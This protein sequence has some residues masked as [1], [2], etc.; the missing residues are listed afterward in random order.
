MLEHRAAASL[1]LIGSLAC[2]SCSID[3]SGEGAQ[4]TEEKRFQVGTEVNLTVRTFDGAIEVRSWDRNEVAVQI[5]RR[6]PTPQE[7]EALEVRT[8]QEGNRIVI[9][10]QEPRDRRGLSFGSSQS[11]AVSFILR[12]PRQVTVD[13]RS[14]DGSITVGGIAGVIT[15]RTGD[16]AIRGEGLEGRIQ[17]HTGDGSIRIRDVSGSVDADSGD[18]SIELLGRFDELRAHS[19]DGS[20]R[21]EA[22]E[23][24]AM[25]ADWSVTTGDGSIRV[26]VPGAFDAE[27]DARSGDGRVRANWADLERR[28]DNDERESFRGRLGKGGRTLRISSGDGSVNI[29]RR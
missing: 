18:G 14:G 17:A 2:A 20:V 16:G 13:A 1:A 3:V 28:D 21:I 9:E 4:L 5:E 26:L 12:T 19:G 27:V 7:A 6:G 15:I 8:T 23:G 29:D 11:P 24:S 10:A 25:K 22:E